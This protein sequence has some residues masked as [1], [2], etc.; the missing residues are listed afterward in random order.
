MHDP[1]WTGETIAAATDGELN[2]PFAATG[3]SI[4]TRELQ[5]GDL[6]VPLKDQR[7][8]HE[9]IAAAF[10]AGAAG[11]LSEVPINGHPGVLVDD[12]LAALTRMAETARDRSDAVRI[13]VTGSVGKTSLKEAIATI[14]EGAGRTHKSVKSFNNHWGVPLTL[15]RMPEDAAFG[16]FEMGMNHAGELTELSALVRPDIAVITKIAPAHLEHFNSVDEIALAKAEIFS[17]LAKGGRAIV[18]ADDPYG[19]RLARTARKAGAQVTL[20]GRSE[21]SDFRIG[22][23]QPLLNGSVFALHAQGE[24]HAVRIN[25]AG[26]HWVLNAALAIACAYAAGV[27]VVDAVESVSQIEA[28]AGRGQR[29]LST[30]NGATVTVVD[31]S[32]NANPESMRAAITALA[33]LPGRK[34]AVMGEMLE[35]GEDAPDMHAALSHPLHKSGFDRVITVGETMRALRTALPRKLQA[36]WVAD[37]DGAW[38]ALLGELRDGDTVL[39]KGSNGARLGGLVDRLKRLGFSERHD[40][41]MA[42]EA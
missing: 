30:V 1:I 28:M 37:A 35:L 9:F 31:E 12:T 22:D 15:A 7:D 11:T 8:G 17:G 36:A 26:E 23:V 42:R 29:F 24:L 10:R 4:D 14:C 38:D 39:V 34:I 16:V 20:V 18:N 32:Y 13:G 2:A 33:D 27:P 6:F 5:P 41:L 25:V 21:K 40:G 3:I 19:A